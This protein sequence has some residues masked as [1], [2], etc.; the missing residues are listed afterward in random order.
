MLVAELATELVLELAR[1]ELATEL[2]FELLDDAI[3]LDVVEDVLLCVLEALS[4]DCALPLAAASEDEAEPPPPPHDDSMRIAPAAQ[5]KRD[6]A[7]ER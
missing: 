1:A 2:D 5:A 7:R 6:A 4:E 3:E